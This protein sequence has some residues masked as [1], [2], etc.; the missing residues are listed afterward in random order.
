MPLLSWPPGA[1]IM[2][3]LVMAGIAAAVRGVVEEVS[4]NSIDVTTLPWTWGQGH[5]RAALA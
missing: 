1:V 2:K 3:G 4:S 5:S